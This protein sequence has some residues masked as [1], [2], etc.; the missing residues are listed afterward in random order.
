ME[1][2]KETERMILRKMFES[3]ETSL[4]EKMYAALHPKGILDGK[5]V[6]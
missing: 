6:L 2:W 1:A 3:I 5:S 4:C